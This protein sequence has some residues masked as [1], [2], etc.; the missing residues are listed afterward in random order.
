[1]MHTITC[2]SASARSQA[3]ERLHITPGPCPCGGS[4]IAPAVAELSAGTRPGYVQILHTA[5]PDASELAELKAAGFRYAARQ[6]PPRWYGL[7][8]RAPHAYA[9]AVRALMPESFEAAS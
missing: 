3:G 4:A 8:T 1:M 9:P 5:R 2:R 7:A 6:C